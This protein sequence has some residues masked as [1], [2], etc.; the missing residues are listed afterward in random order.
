MESQ[1]RKGDE[2]QTLMEKKYGR[3]RPALTR[4]QKRT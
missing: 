2:M 3:L 4:K 1:K